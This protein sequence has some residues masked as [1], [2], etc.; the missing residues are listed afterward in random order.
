M[1]GGHEGRFS[2]DPLPVFSAQ[3]PCGHGQ[4]CPLF[5][6]VHPVFP[7]PTTT[8][9]TLQVVLKDSFGEALMACE[10]PEPTSVVINSESPTTTKHVSHVEI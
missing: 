1:P 9:P 2:R 8:S 6:V 7:L 10:M 4:E 5:D 3:G